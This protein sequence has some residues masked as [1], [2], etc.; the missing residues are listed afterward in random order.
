MASAGLQ[1]VKIECAGDAARIGRH[2]AAIEVISAS[3]AC[4]VTITDSV[5]RDCAGYPVCRQTAV[6]KPPFTSES[7]P[8]L[9]NDHDEVATRN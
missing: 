3:A 8:S 1:Q 6:K 9:R 7:L 5:I 2:R 4:N